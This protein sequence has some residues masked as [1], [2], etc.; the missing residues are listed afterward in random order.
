MQ[1][2]YE[3]RKC[4]EKQCMQLISRQTYGNFRDCNA[5]PSPW[6]LCLY[7]DLLWNVRL[8]A[9]HREIDSLKVG[10]RGSQARKIEGSL[11]SPFRPTIFFPPNKEGKDL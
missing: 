11:G 6:A 5:V 9:N 10:G 1:I 8:L 3:E 4:T 2:N 7:Q